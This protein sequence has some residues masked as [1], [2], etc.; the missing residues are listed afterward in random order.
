M[1]K[2]IIKG[3]KEA[4]AF[5]QGDKSKGRAHQ[6]RPPEKDKEHSRDTSKPTTESGS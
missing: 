2:G 3:A 4:L 1:T 5:L 6:V